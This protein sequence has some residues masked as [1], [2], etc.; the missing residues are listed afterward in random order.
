MEIKGW[1]RTSLVDFGGHI[2]TVL[3]VGG[4]DWRCP[5]CHNPDLVLRPAL[6]PAL[7]VEE[8]LNHLARRA[9]LIEGVVVK[10]LQNSIAAYAKLRSH[11]PVAGETDAVERYTGEVQRKLWDQM[12]LS[13]G[14]TPPP[15]ATTLINAMNDMFDIAATRKAEREA[16]IPVLVVDVVLLYA[17]LSAGIVGYV[18]GA[19]EPKHRGVT[20]ILFVLLTLSL[21]LI[22]DLD[23]PWRGGITISQQPMID[24]VEG[25]GPQ[26]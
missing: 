15:I 19:S 6:L 11:L 20:F 17:L 26:T 12:Q 25:I 13:L 21:S 18:L 5:M 1:T 16:Q 9:G 8:V 23:R 24:L 4:C 7:A 10:A 3:F 14:A 2:A 22:L